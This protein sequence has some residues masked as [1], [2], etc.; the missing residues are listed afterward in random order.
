MNRYRWLGL[1]MMM[2]V[3]VFCADT[4]ADVIELR[5]GRTFEGKILWQHGGKIKIDCMIGSIRSEMEFRMTEVVSVKREELPAD[6]FEKKKRPKRASTKPSSSTRPILRYTVMPIHG[7]F[8]E[9]VH[10]EDVERVLERAKRTSDVII[11]DIDSDGGLVAEADDVVKVLDAF[12]DDLKYIALVRRGLSAA[13]WVAFRC[14]QILMIEGGTFGGAVAY[15]RDTFGAIEVDAKL[16]SVLAA[17]IGAMAEKQ[18]HHRAVAEAMIVMDKQLVGWFDA[19]DTPRL[20]ATAPAAQP[21]VTVIDD[22]KSVLTLTSGDA[23]F[24]NL[25]EIVPPDIE[26]DDLGSVVAP[27]ARWKR[28]SRYGEIVHEE[29]VEQWTW[30]KEA[31]GERAAMEQ[32][33]QA[34]IREAVAADPDRRRYP[35]EYTRYWSDSAPGW[36]WGHLPTDEAWNAWRRNTDNAVAIWSRAGRTLEELERIESLAEHYHRQR[37]FD[38]TALKGMYE[39]CVRETKRIKGNRSRGP[40]V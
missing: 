31:E 2:L 4:A 26:P 22:P 24:W 9:T 10:A 16:N 21:N 6:F 32:Q 34:N 27:D 8:G 3:G 1:A 14:D 40:N 29:A 28:G 7:V 36:V 15:S 25:A 18:G 19:E 33:A 30:W 13:I 23:S 39:R 35:S 37:L 12:D 5:D 20:A 11:F 17:D 38:R